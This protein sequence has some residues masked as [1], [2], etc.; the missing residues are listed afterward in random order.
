MS[1][2]WHRRQKTTLYCGKIWFSHVYM[3]KRLCTL[4]N[5][6]QTTAKLQPKKKRKRRKKEKEV[7]GF[8]SKL[9]AEDG[10]INIHLT[11]QA[12]SMQSRV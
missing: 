11:F 10:S 8:P 7:G 3:N 4:A 1:I 12:F 2:F 6:S 5:H 9:Q